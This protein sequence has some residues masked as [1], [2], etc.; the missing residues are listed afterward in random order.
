[1]EFRGAAWA[2]D[3]C[4]SGFESAWRAAAVRAGAHVDGE[5]VGLDCLRVG[6]AAD[7]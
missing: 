2:V 3:G 4:E 5:S 6:G 7:S 1:M